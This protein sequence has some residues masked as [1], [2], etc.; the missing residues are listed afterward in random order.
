MSGA[1]SLSNK[2]GLSGRI[3]SISNKLAESPLL[4]AFLMN[5]AAFLFRIVVFEVKYEVSDDY[6]TDAVLSGAYGIGYD[7]NL[8]FGN[9]CNKAFINSI[10]N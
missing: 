4:L 1:E 9:L 2:E 5:L 10:L 3:K 7:P 6:F 8:L